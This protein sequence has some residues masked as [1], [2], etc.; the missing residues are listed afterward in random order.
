MAGKKDSAPVPIVEWVAPEGGVWRT[1]PIHKLPPTAIYDAENVTFRNGEVKVRSGLATY[2]SPI[3]AAARVTGAHYFPRTGAAHVTVFG[4]NT[5]LYMIDPSSAIVNLTGVDVLTGADSN[6]NQFTT[7]VIGSPSTANIVQGNGKDP[8]QYWD[9]VVATFV[10]CA[11]SPPIF[12]DLVTAFDRIVGITPPYTVRW[13]EARSLSQWPEL[14][15]RNLIDSEDPVVA[16]R[17][18]GTMNVIVYKEQSIW[19]GMARGGSSAQAFS[20][21]LRGFYDGPAN[22]AAITAV[23]NVHYYM[24][25]EGRIGAYDGRTHQWV[26]DGVWAKISALIDKTKQY[27]IAAVYDPTTHEVLFT[28]PKTTDS[29]YSTGLVILTLPRPQFGIK[30]FGAW[31]GSWLV[32]IS[33]MVR[34]KHADNSDGVV[35]FRAT[36]GSFN[37]TKLTPLVGDLG[38]PFNCLWQSGLTP[39]PDLGIMRPELETF[40]FRAAMAGNVTAKLTSTYLLD[41]VSGTLSDGQTIS[42]SNVEPIEKK[43]FSAVKGRFFGYQYSCT[44]TDLLSWRGALLHGRKVEE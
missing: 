6:L 28:Y 27:A 23:D 22:P 19:A 11:C 7:I 44:S 36:A 9:G 15:A 17:N 26:G 33:T 37:V 40:V 20:F 43:A 1:I 14:N 42:L 4:T 10:E 5:G 2:A 34:T 25:K 41:T 39:T 21:E 8:I 35:A 24:T 12:S 29:T 31:P 18:I 13:G 16:I 30:S 3:S 38:T 32:P